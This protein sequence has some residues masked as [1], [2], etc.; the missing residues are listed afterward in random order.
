MEASKE[1][2]MCALSKETFWKPSE[3]EVDYEL[4]EN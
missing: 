2:F 3:L 1:V 4:I